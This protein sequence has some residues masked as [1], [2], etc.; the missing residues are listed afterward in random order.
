M[1][2]KPKLEKD[3]NIEEE[4]INAIK[5]LEDFTYSYTKELKKSSKDMYKFGSDMTQQLDMMLKSVKNNKSKENIL[6]TKFKVYLQKQM[7]DVM[8]SVS[9]GTI[10]NMNLEAELLKYKK[11]AIELGIT[12][13]DTNE[14]LSIL[15]KGQAKDLV[16]IAT[17]YSKMNKDGETL[18]EHMKKINDKAKEINDSYEG[19]GKTI[20]DWKDNLKAIIQ[21][22]IVA[23]TTFATTVGLHLKGFVT[24]LEST[25]KEL[26]LSTTQGIALGKEIGWAAL[27]GAFLGL[28][29]E[30]TAQ[31]AAALGKEMPNAI[32]KAEDIK[33]VARM[34]D[35]YGVGAGEV[36][37]LHKVLKIAN[38]NSS[39]LANSSFKTMENISK[40]AGVPFGQVMAD[41]AGQTEFFV[42][43]SKNGGENIMKAAVSAKQLGLGLN[44][45]N[46]MAEKLLDVDS[47]IQAE[48][49]ASVLTGKALNFNKARELAYAGDMDGMMKEALNNQ[50]TM[51]EWDSYSSIQKQSI[52]ESL[53]QSVESM[54]TM[55]SQ[56]SE[57]DKTAELQNSWWGSTYLFIRDSAKGVMNYKDVL[58]SSFNML[59]SITQMTGM[60]GKA[61]GIFSIFKKGKGVASAAGDIANT[62][63]SALSSAAKTPGTGMLSKMTNVFKGISMADVG[64]FAMISG[65]MVVT[66]IGLSFGLKKFNDVEWSSVGKGI[67]SLTSLII[68]IQFIGNVSSQVLM[69]AFAIGILGASLIPLSFALNMFNTVNWESIIKGAASIGIFTGMIFGLGALI[70]SGVGAILFVAGVAGFIALGSALTILG[71]GL[72]QVVEPMSQFS[73]FASSLIPQIEQL[74]SLSSSFANIG[75]GFSKMGWGLMTMAA[76]ALLLSPLLPVLSSI[77][78]GNNSSTENKESKGSNID[79][80]ISKIDG[81]VNALNSERIIQV[82]SRAISKVLGIQLDKI[83]LYNS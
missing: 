21:N 5:E 1:A 11:E 59:A 65:I 45:V 36:A 49:E 34:S 26:G 76:G 8:K 24:S 53:G 44:E 64:K 79:D 28:S 37:K 81:L 69:G 82:D 29:M 42:K 58:A 55:I 80:L 20:K 15:Y 68:G 70:S 25:R 10:T 39:Q 31:A 78:I 62:G 32:P 38:G 33:T 43:Y 18:A 27:Q 17:E 60:S 35:L 66:L 23:F 41:V 9:D 2:K 61:G 14:K 77:G 3:F 73:S 50:F 46:Q 19:I 52:A 67:L 6:D 7:N 12:D 75:D 47:S 56:Q 40:A 71:F 4:Y 83:K 22:P 16:S 74:A 13:I 63:G 54:N 57:L 51:S 30:E 48:M 72:Q